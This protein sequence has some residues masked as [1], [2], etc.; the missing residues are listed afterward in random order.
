MPTG[1]LYYKHPNE[2]RFV[3]GGLVEAEDLLGSPLPQLPPP[4]IHEGQRVFLVRF[5]PQLRTLA[6]KTI[7]GLLTQIGQ[8][9]AACTPRDDAALAKDQADYE[10]ML[11]HALEAVSAADR[12]L[13]LVNLFWLAHTR[14]LAECL[15]EME[16]RLP[17]IRKLKY[18]LHPLLSNIHR[19]IDQVVR[20]DAARA[21]PAEHAAV[22]G[23]QSDT[24]L[25]EALIEDGFA[26]TEVSVKD[27][28]FNQFLAANKRYRLSAELFFEIY[29]LLLR[30]TERRLREGDRTLVGR[31]TRHMPELAKDQYL[32]QSGI[33]K[34][35]MNG[36]V[37]TYLFG[38]AWSTGVKLM[39]SA[40]IRSESE[41]RRPAEIMDS[42][43]EFLTNVKRF[44]IISY[45]RDR[46]LLLRSFGED[47]LGDRATQELRHYDLSE[48]AQVLNNA[49]NVTILFL[50]LRGFTKTSE[51]Q[52]SERDL[53]R[54]LYTV[55]DAFVPILRRFG[56]TI[57]KFLGDGMMVTFGTEHV[58]ELD[59][60][61]ALRAAILCQDALRR[62]RLEGQTYYK[63]GV[64]IHYGRAYLAH[65][66]ADEVRV[67]RTIIGRNVNLAGRLSSAARRGLEPEESAAPSDVEAKTSGLRV[68]IDRD[69][70][71][72]NEG[73]ALSQDALA[74]IESCLP[75]MEADEEGPRR[76]YY[77]D[78]TIGRQLILRYVG[79]AKFKGV[80][81][82]LPVYEADYEV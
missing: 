50:D 1:S 5:H 58:D 41:R 15:R 44:E 65:F 45:V 17:A 82:S 70:V 2:S 61:N 40:K 8:D 34:I 32:T 71:L 12:R 67:Q 78:E 4:E 56:G 79:D 26:V 10:A 69:G 35:M 74:Q 22:A 21:N 55:F 49:L 11:A 46:V 47:D 52:I 54:E 24:G 72:V 37:L 33:T 73:I 23:A 28:D 77:F 60:V 76:L 27:L 64:A 42:F 13:G 43:V 80:R 68:A 51:G 6:R 36:H 19:R 20:R 31:V 14:D 16:S 18:S 53:T 29:S 3:A 57:D 30:E 81:S 38:D 75:L 66:I 62:L 59:P 9:A 48:S 7:Q 25:V 39:A 63:M